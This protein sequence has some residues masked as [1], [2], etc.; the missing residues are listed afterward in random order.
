M[1]YDVTFT[2][3]T[4]C[5]GVMRAVD[6]V[7]N[8]DDETARMLVDLGVATAEG[9]SP[10]TGSS[11][12]L[13]AD[14]FLSKADNLSTVASPSVARSNIDATSPADI[15]SA[16]AG[17][18]SKAET[19]DNAREYKT[20]DFV[21]FNNGVFVALKDGVNKMPVF[22][23]PYWT[24]VGM[25]SNWLDNPWKG[26][27]FSNT[28]SVGTGTGNNGSGTPAYA[29]L[30]LTSTTTD[31]NAVRIARVLSI[32]VPTYWHM[33]A[34]RDSGI[35]QGSNRINFAKAGRLRYNVCTSNRTNAEIAGVKWYFDFGRTFSEVS[36]SGTETPMD[37]ELNRRGFGWQCT[38]SGDSNVFSS[39]EAVYHDGTTL[40]KQELNFASF[41]IS[42]AM[43]RY[44]ITWNGLGS[45][46]YFVNGK[47]VARF[48]DKNNDLFG[49][50]T[51]CCLAAGGYYGPNY[52]GVSIDHMVWVNN[53]ETG[54]LT[55]GTID[56]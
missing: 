17:Y 25:G 49:M 45:Y 42:G 40:Y 39:F 5:K 35:V 29:R 53:E 44:E 51:W 9:L 28:K 22:E 27:T 56:T 31:N 4:L 16:V 46:A 3:E 1:P 20:G 11:A 19:W 34:D 30:G 26:L 10:Q 23:I 21:L 2:Q 32:G 41:W 36:G 55:Y 15:A 48:N 7:L 37:S 52:T 8:V 50:P 43:Q 12:A 38:M 54:F 24:N 13:F 6:E 33:L 47:E 14:T 18:P